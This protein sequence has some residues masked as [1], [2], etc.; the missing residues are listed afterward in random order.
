MS[1]Y[2]IKKYKEMLEDGLVVQ[3][4]RPCDPNAG[5]PGSSPGQGTRSHR[6]QLSIHIVTKDPVCC[7][8]D[9][10]QPNKF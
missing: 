9:P 10:V 5:R 8:K 4:P 6:P 7:S 1:L 3:W 2:P